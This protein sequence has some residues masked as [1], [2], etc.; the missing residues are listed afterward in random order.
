MEEEIKTRVEHILEQVRPYLKEDGGD[1]EYVRYE[2]E[3]RVLEVRL[4][5]NCKTCPLA[6]MTLRAGIERFIL[7]EIPEVRRIENIR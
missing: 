7:S 4:L 2:A 6:L 5:G 3:T 1:V